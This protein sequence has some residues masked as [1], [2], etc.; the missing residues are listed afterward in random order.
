M[1]LKK[2]ETEKIGNVTMLDS[3]TKKQVVDYLSILD[4]AVIN[5]RKNDLF[6]TVIPSKIFETAAMQIPI[7]IGVDGEARKIV[8]YYDAGL[9]YEPENGEDFIEKLYE[10]LSSD[11]IILR[12]KKGCSKLA[13]AYDRKDLAKKMYDNLRAVYEKG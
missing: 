7:L 8:E 2:A 1:L 11:E 10:I 6:K 3:V 13:R 4:A 12:F 5:L 9:Y